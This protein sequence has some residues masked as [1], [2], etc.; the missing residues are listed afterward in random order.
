MKEQYDINKYDETYKIGDLVAYYIGDVDVGNKKKLQRKFSGPFTV[1]KIVN[2]NTVEIEKLHKPGNI[3][4]VENKI[5][6]DKFA[7]HTSM[8]KLYHRD[9]FIPFSTVKQSK[10]AS[11]ERRE[12]D[13]KQKKLRR[14]SRL[15]KQKQK[16]H[17]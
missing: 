6:G 9:H 7:C 16:N 1:A 17:Q 11:Q 8:L 2:H 3:V 15:R 12:K 13:R 4:Q 14:S 5:T 10:L